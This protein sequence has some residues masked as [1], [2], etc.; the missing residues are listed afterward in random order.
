MSWSSFFRT[1]ISTFTGVEL[2]VYILFGKKKYIK[3]QNKMLIFVELFN[4]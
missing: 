4:N 3:I 2:C 1:L